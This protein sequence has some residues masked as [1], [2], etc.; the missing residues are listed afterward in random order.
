MKEGF[1]A[2][3]KMLQ[4]AQGMDVQALKRRQDQVVSD[5]LQLVPQLTE[6]RVT[7]PRVA[8]VA[9]DN[10]F[11]LRLALTPRRQALLFDIAANPKEASL[12]QEVA[13]IR[14]AICRA[15]LQ[16]RIAANELLDW[17]AGPMQSRLDPVHELIFRRSKQQWSIENESGQLCLAFVNVPRYSI[18]KV[19]CRIRGTVEYVSIRSIGLRNVEIFAKNAA[20]S[21]I[22]QGGRLRVAQPHLVTEPA[23]N[24]APKKPEVRLAH[25]VELGATLHRCLLTR[26]PLGA[27]ATGELFDSCSAPL[28]RKPNQS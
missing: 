13:L 26:R 14:K 22:P 10:S 28:L 23:H 16:A 19:S 21:E 24:F 8:L 1:I 3:L 15:P 7:E 2:D 18:D 20:D 12:H 9:G 25:V 27:I 5:L 11:W 17:A 6:L 4:F